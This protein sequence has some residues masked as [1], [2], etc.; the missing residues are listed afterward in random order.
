MCSKFNYILEYPSKV[1]SFK[2]KYNSKINGNA[3]DK[4]YSLNK[5][6][7]DLRHSSKISSK[8]NKVKD[9]DD[10]KSVTQADPIEFI[11]RENIVLVNEYSDA[12]YN[13]SSQ[14]IR[15]FFHLQQE[16]LI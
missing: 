1:K 6:P 13:N 8:E 5:P 4:E 10:S 11:K 15:Y 2:N 3:E 16:L 7:L 14:S 9:I 12:Y